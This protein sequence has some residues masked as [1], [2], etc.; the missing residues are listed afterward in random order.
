MKTPIRLVLTSLVVL[1]LGC[2]GLWG[3]NRFTGTSEIALTGPIG[4]PFNGYV[5]ESG[6]RIDISGALPWSFQGTNVTKFEIRKV[7]PSD[8]FNYQFVHKSRGEAFSS[9]H[10]KPNETGVKVR[11][12]FG[13]MQV[14]LFKR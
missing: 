8:S 10:V 6:R 7:N 4:V 12:G 11:M 9:G 2:F 14:R 3:L 1:T 5:I 13:S